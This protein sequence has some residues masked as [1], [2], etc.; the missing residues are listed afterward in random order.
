MAKL[1]IT[2]PVFRHAPAVTFGRGAVRSLAALDDGNTAFLLSGSELVRQS[3]D[4]ALRRANGA[5]SPTNCFA[6]PAGEPTT[7]SVREA[8]KFLSNRTTKRVVAVG[9]GSVLDWARLAWAEASGL[10]DLD[11]NDF[12]HE[13][14]PHEHTEFWL[15]PTTC[16]TGA[17]AAD[18]VVYT[19]DNG[20]KCSV[21]SPAFLAHQVVLDGRFL[22]A[23]S[24]SRLASF[25]SDALSHAVE[26]Y[27][28]VVPN[29]LAKEMALS[30][31]NVILSN[32]STDPDPSAKDRLMEASF[33][34]G[35]AAANCSVG[36]VHAFAH[37]VGTDGVPHGVANACALEAGLAFNAQTPQMGD[38]LKRLGLRDGDE[39]ARKIRPITSCALQDLERYPTISRLQDPAYRADVAERMSNDVTIRSNPRRP[40]PDDRIGFVEDVAKRL[41]SR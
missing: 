3:V 17:E 4:E 23:L 10:I 30:A 39:L 16:G 11:S 36:I 9:G 28:S 2:Y 15:V 37:T 21:V 26:S 8:A 20:V 22:D 25:V 1:T 24:D 31:L 7:A 33:S 38:L 34:G 5:L 6:K 32:F 27:L 41:F 18:V 12:D 13:K 40:T 35:V 29:F 19:N 14:A